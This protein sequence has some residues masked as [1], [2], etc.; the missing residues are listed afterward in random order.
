MSRS[1]FSLS[2]AFSNFKKFEYHFSFAGFISL[3]Y[4]PYSSYAISHCLIVI[5]RKLCL[6]HS[7][8]SIT[9]FILILIS[10]FLIFLCSCRRFFFKI[11]INNLFSFQA[12]KIGLPS[13]FCHNG[14]PLS[15]PPPAH[16]GIPPYQLDPKTIGK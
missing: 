13:F 8:V 1:H 14:D 11:K 7:V 6:F 5:S 16:C 9:C 3:S 15:T 4:Y 12:N 2:I 10:H